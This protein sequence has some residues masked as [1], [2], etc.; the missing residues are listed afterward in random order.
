MR[1]ESIY[2]S[3]TRPQLPLMSFI[4]FLIRKF[5]YYII[6]N[7]LDNILDA[8]KSIFLF[9]ETMRFIRP[10]RAKMELWLNLAWI[11]L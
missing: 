3:N 2:S 4:I 10:T 5:S 9:K 8:E 6:A 1:V 11:K 7:D